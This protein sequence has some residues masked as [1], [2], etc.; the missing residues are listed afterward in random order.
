M[1]ITLQQREKGS[2]KFFDDVLDELN[3]IGSFFTGKQFEVVFPR[4]DD[5]YIVSYKPGVFARDELRRYYT[6][7]HCNDKTDDQIEKYLDRQEKEFETWYE[8][9]KENVGDYR[10]SVVS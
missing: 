8:E 2:I 7:D 5:G 6:Y 1:S 9:N 4:N 10:V 3:L